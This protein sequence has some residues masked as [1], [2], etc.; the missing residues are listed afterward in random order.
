MR[1]M[2]S[3][4]SILAAPPPS[5]SLVAEARSDTAPDPKVGTFTQ[6]LLVAMAHHDPDA[7]TGMFRFPAP[8]QS[9]PVTIPIANG[10]ALAKA[11]DTVFTP[12]LGCAIERG[13][14]RALQLEPAGGSFVITK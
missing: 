14:N 12:E 9:G 4:A 2:R 1:R 3:L 11:Y 13:N 6:R 10:A 7:L 5:G 8:V